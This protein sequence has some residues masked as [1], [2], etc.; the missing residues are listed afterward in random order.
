MCIIGIEIFCDEMGIVIYDDEKG[1]L[2]YKF[3]S[4]VKLYVDYGG[5]VFELVL[6]DYVKKII[7]FIK[8]VMVEVNVM[9]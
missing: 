1:L 5:V 9:L 6:C 7:L 4:Q 8:V 3:Y 2:F